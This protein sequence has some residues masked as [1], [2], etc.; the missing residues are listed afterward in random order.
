MD[1]FEVALEVAVRTR[2]KKLI[3][4]GKGNR[5]GLKDLPSREMTTESMGT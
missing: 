2:A 3:N 5:Y 4:L 1:P